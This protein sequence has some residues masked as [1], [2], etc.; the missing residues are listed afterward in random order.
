MGYYQVASP[1][2]NKHCSSWT[3]SWFLY[4][5]TC[6]LIYLLSTHFGI[7]EWHCQ[8]DFSYSSLIPSSHLRRSVKRLLPMH[9]ITR[10]HSLLPLLDWS[11]NTLSQLGLTGALLCD[12]V[13]S[14]SYKDSCLVSH[15]HILYL[16]SSHIVVFCVWE[17]WLHLTC[18][19]MYL[20][21]ALSKHAFVSLCLELLRD[22]RGP[23]KRR[24]VHS[25][26]LPPI[27]EIIKGN[28]KGNT[29]FT[30][31]KE[32]TLPGH[33]LVHIFWSTKRHEWVTAQQALNTDCRMA[34]WTHS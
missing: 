10:T 33:V 22:S 6:C 19:G 17:Q 8:Q 34:H 30:V 31:E 26:C 20:D 23:S 24:V 18:E 25:F 32:P 9:G 21:A 1:C 7:R 11:L 3:I 28:E 14:L 5:Y 29:F 2:L 13:H 16:L 12:L 4:S 27:L 15:F